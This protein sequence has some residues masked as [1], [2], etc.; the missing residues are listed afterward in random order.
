MIRLAVGI[1]YTVYRMEDTHVA[2]AF[3]SRSRQLEDRLDLS[4]GGSARVTSRTHETR[5]VL[6]DVWHPEPARA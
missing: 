1:F 3:M 6:S 2:Q 4:E 5:R